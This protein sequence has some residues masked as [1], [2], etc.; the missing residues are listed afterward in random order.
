MEQSPIIFGG[1]GEPQARIK[2]NPLGSDARRHGALDKATQ[3]RMHLIDNISL[4]MR[5]TC[6]VTILFGLPMH[7]AY[8]LATVGHHGQHVWVGEATRH[9]VDDLR[10]RFHSGSSHLGPHCVH[11]DPHSRLREFSHY[12]NDAALFRRGVDTLRTWAGGLPADV[13]NVCPLSQELTGVIDGHVLVEVAASV[14]KRI[15]RN[16]DNSHDHAACH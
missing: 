13:N 2:D 14:G 11:A 3:L 10:A 15:L 6:S 8:A 1:F 7:E 12:G 4:N 5:L 16:I 9:I